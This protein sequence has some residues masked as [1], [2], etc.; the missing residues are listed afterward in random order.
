MSAHIVTSESRRIGDR[1][2][3]IARMRLRL[4]ATEEADLR[5][6][7]LMARRLQSV[8]ARL[9]S[10]VASQF[11]RPHGAGVGVMAPFLNLV[12]RWINRAALDALTIRA[13]ERILDVGFGG[14]VGMRVALQQV[15]DGHVTGIDLS[16]EVVARARRRLRTEID[17]GRLTVIE[18]SVERLPLPGDAFDGAYTVNT[19]YFWPDVPAGLAELWRVLA[20][21][22]R[23][24]VAMESGARRE[25][26]VFFGGVAPTPAAVAELLGKAGFVD[27]E[28]RRQ[29]GGVELLVAR[30]S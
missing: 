25:H 28:A 11:A 18:G 3:R 27:V 14:G 20:P 10:P 13:G 26:G 12:N 6:D 2:Q 4:N 9:S 21:E 23:L 29:R 7:G 5:Q 15:G 17:R 24:V 22:G 1:D 19:V 8:L 30:K 16:G